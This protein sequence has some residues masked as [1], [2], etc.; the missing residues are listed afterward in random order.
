MIIPMLLLG[1]MQNSY[2]AVDATIEW[3]VRTTGNNDNGGGYDLTNNGGTDYSQQDAAQ[4]TLTD[5]ATSG[6]G[7]T[8]LTSVTGGFTSAMVDNIIQIKSGT[9][10]T[11]GFYEIDVYTDT[12]TVT[13]SSAPD[14]G[15]GGIASGTGSVGGG[16]LTL[17]K[18]DDA[19]VAGN[20]IH[21]KS[22]SYAELL[23]LETAGADG[24]PIIW[25]GYHTSHNDEPIGAN[26]PIIEGGST[27][28][29][30]LVADQGGNVFEHF[31]FQNATADGVVGGQY[32]T[33]LNCRFTNNG[34]NG[35]DTTTISTL[36]SCEG[37]TNGL[38]QLWGGADT[39]YIFCYAHDGT[40]AGINVANVSSAI[41]SISDTNGGHNFYSAS[42]AFRYI[43]C[44]S[45]NSTTNGYV[46]NQTT[47]ARGSAIIN[48]IA[49]DNGTYGFDRESTTD[50]YPYFDYNCYHN[51]TTANL[52]NL[53]SGLNDITSDPSFVNAAA[54]DFTVSSGSPIL[55]VGAQPST[56]IGLTGDYKWNIGADQD[57]NV[58]GGGGGGG[59]RCGWS[60]Q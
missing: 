57:D 7:V 31:I 12:N 10:V 6:V 19:V 47:W 21:V 4:L 38:Y 5:L 20:I 45:Y 33:Y 49:K 28:T 24:L 30:C 14:D 16:L 13:L 9:N 27:R 1:L 60:I 29:N 34:A 52:N 41:G 2:S 58:S 15:V 46:F 3:E 53:A 43:N 18:V 54:G 8:T 59:R 37:D 35:I 48:C 25:R 56:D 32:Q 11:A 36:I 51:N 44:V 55:D 40:N 17:E 50:T 23:N 42:Y 22:G 39:T 26:R